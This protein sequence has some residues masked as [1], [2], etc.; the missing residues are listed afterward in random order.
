VQQRAVGHPRHQARPKSMKRYSAPEA[1][2]P[3]CR[4]KPTS[5]VRTS[6]RPDAALAAPGAQSSTA[7][8]AALAAS[9]PKAAQAMRACAS[10]TQERS[11]M[12]SA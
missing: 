5:S 4:K 8:S 6:Q 3:E 7:A 12:V 1:I 10:T 11:E 2:I 9:T